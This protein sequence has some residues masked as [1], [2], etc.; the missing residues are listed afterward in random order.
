MVV[1]FR[2]KTKEGKGVKREARQGC[3]DALSVNHIRGLRCYL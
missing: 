3:Q 1:T 2:D